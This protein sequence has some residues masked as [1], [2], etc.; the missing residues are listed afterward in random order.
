MLCQHLWTSICIFSIHTDA[1]FCGSTF[2]TWHF[3][4]TLIYLVINKKPAALLAALL[5]MTKCFK[6]C[7]WYS[8]QIRLESG[9][10]SGLLAASMQQWPH[11]QFEKY[12][13]FHP[14][15]S[16]FIIRMVTKKICTN[17]LIICHELLLLSAKIDDEHPFTFL[18]HI[19]LNHFLLIRS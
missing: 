8:K 9:L 12:A 18:Q 10:S 19:N 13:N 3:A 17:P 7:I 5:V 1:L 11:T 15:T 16:Q 14:A 2:I 6:Y 4:V